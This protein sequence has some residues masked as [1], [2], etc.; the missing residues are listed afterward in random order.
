MFTHEE[1]LEG[2]A[3]GR[4]K[5]RV[6]P[7]IYRS[8]VEPQLSEGYRRAQKAAE[9]ASI[10][11]LILAVPVYL[12][13]GWLFGALTVVGGMAIYIYFRGLNY[14]VFVRAQVKEN[15]EFFDFCQERAVI[16]IRRNPEGNS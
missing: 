4:L 12:L 1:F 13:S 10:L 9:G 5:F 6:N 16:L 14:R 7:D 2:K 11:I 15:K 3:S 8:E